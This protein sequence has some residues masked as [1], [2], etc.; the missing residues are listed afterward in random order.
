M[1]H[2]I[3]AGQ[4]REGDTSPWSPALIISSVARTLPPPVGFSSTLCNQSS[5]RC[6]SDVDRC[7]QKCVK[8]DHGGS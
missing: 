7:Y 1:G 2:G 5:T 6:G 8:Q 4:G 3:S